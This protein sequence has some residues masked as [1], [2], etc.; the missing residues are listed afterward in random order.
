MSGCTSS[1]PALRSVPYRLIVSA[2]DARTLAERVLALFGDDPGRPLPSAAE[3]GRRLGL[4]VSTLRRRLD[5]EGT[6]YRALKDECRRTAALRYLA[7]PA[8]SLADVAAL[9]GFDEPSAFFRAFRRWTGT[10]PA[11]YRAG[12]GVAAGA[13]AAGHGADGG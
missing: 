10:T 2:H 11:R 6:S 3:V 8:L 5:E 13:G 7:S 1:A 9:L 4:S 12:I